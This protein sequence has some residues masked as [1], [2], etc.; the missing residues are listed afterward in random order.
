ML[1]FLIASI[2]IL[3][4]QIGFGTIFLGAAI[5]LF[6]AFCLFIRDLLVFTIDWCFKIR[7]FSNHDF[8]CCS[9]YSFEIKKSIVCDWFPA[10]A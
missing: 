7:G 4:L 3:G 9:S 8:G 1:L 5:H 6:L 2:M 10:K